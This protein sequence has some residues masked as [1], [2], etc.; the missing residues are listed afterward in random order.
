MKNILPEKFRI[1]IDLD[2]KETYRIIEINSCIK[3]DKKKTVCFIQ[4]Q[5]RKSWAIR[6]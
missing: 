3:G 1:E 6:F 2:K 4:I 5:Q